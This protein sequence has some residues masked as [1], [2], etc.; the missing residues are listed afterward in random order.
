M[1]PSVFGFGTGLPVAVFALVA[2]LGARAAAK[3]FQAVG[4]VEKWARIVTGV[5]FL[6]IGIWFTLAYTFGL[7]T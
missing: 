3:A 7:A 1:I 4:K 5:V 2:A 6:V